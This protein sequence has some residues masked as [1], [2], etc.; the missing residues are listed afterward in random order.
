M[1]IKLT[2]PDG[3]QPLAIERFRSSGSQVFAR[4]SASP[5]Q[6]YVGATRW[7][8]RDLTASIPRANVCLKAFAR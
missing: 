3:N 8:M 4:T 7:R 2:S 6:S 1:A 5:G